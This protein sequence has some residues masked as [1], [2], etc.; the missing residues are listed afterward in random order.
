MAN[1]N[2]MVR[3]AK[4]SGTATV[5]IRVRNGKQDFKL[6]TKVDIPIRWWEEW[7][8]GTNAFTKNLD[9]SLN[10]SGKEKADALANQLKEIYETIKDATTQYNELSAKLFNEVMDKYHNGLKVDSEESK[11]PNNAADYL[12]IK[13]EEM[14]SGTMEYKGNR[15]DANTIKVWNSFLKLLR[16]FGK[17]RGGAVYLDS[18]NKALADEFSKYLK[19]CDYLPKTKN[20]YIICF[21]ALIGF[22]YD[23]DLIKS[24]ENTQK[25]FYK[26][27]VKDSDKA[28]K[29]Y[30]NEEELQALYDMDLKVGSMKDKVR[31]IFLCGCYTAQRVS[32][33]G[34]FTPDNFR[35]TKKGNKVVA[36]IQTKT[37]N[38]VI[39]PYLSDNLQAIVEKYN[40]AL[41]SVGD[42]VINRYIKQIGKEL[43]LHVPSLATLH[44]TV[45]TQKEKASEKA[46]KMEFKRNKSGDVFRPRYEMI[47]T[48]TAR[49]S[50]ITNLWLRDIFSISQLMQVS[51]HKT[52]K[53][54]NE[55]LC[56]S[57]TEIADKIADKLKKDNQ[58]NTNLF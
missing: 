48:H 36:L 21:K 49:R 43:S 16:A 5:Y 10:P 6:S 17:S 53:A 25:H 54:F 14:K 38:E 42:V 4:T 47:C 33:Y 44:K 22:A 40:Y 30:L 55:Y 19:D 12:A 35:V 15:Y 46:G 58:R 34:N 45:L 13:I 7:D 23:D 51:G 56:M 57:Q 39:V 41:P 27:K 28:T 11:L 37:D 3:S 24:K 9:K 52:E 20:K 8:N 29:I 1:V 31:D 18:I 2:F 32:D 26:V 50:A